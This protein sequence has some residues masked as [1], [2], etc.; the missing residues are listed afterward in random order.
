MKSPPPPLLLIFFLL[1]YH[2]L[3]IAAEEV[4]PHT[5]KSIS[6]VGDG[7]LELIGPGKMTVKGKSHRYRKGKY[8][9]SRHI[10]S[11]STIE[12]ISD[13]CILHYASNDYSI[14][15]TLRQSCKKVIG[16]INAVEQ[17]PDTSKLKMKLPALLPNRAQ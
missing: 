15:I 1:Q 13:A 14:N 12:G 5:I 7:F 11:L 9:R 8:I 6:S 10:D 4:I 16:I 17:R 3:S 2:T